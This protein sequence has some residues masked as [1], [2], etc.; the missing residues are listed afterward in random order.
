MTLPRFV[1]GEVAATP[2][3]WAAVDGDA[4]RLML[5]VARHI[6]GDWGDLCAEDVAANEAAIASGGRILSAYTLAHGARVWVITEADRASTAI[7]LPEED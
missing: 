2:G 5:L 7:L 4:D 1:W 6:R 3:A